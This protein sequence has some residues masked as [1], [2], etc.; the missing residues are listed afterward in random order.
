[1]LDVA[2]PEGA[3]FR[4][5]IGA[6]DLVVFPVVGAHRVLAPLPVAGLAEELIVLHIGTHTLLV[7]PAVVLLGAIA[8]ICHDL[9]G[10]SSNGP[11]RMLQMPDRACGV[12]RPLVCRGIVCL[13]KRTF[14]K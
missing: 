12:S 7:E 11:L 2:E 13:V 1:M 5:G 3:S 10:E 14:Q 6:Q 4:A 9:P 8:S